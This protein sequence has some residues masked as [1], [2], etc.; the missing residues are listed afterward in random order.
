MKIHH[1]TAGESRT[2][3]PVPC[4][5]T[6]RARVF[7][8]LAA[9]LLAASSARAE[10]PSVPVEMEVFVR[11]GC[12]RCEEAKRF[13]T[14]LQA[15]RPA[16]QVYYRDVGR[17]PEALAR[18]QELAGRRTAGALGVPAFHVAGRLLVGFNGP[19]TTGRQLVA[20]L[21]GQA[22]GAPDA[23]VCPV[24]GESPECPPGAPLDSIEAP[25]VG[26]VS[27]RDWGLPAFTVVIGLLDGFNPC[28][29][30]VLLFLLSL[31][32]NL[33][34]R[35]KMLAVA[36]TFVLTSGLVYFA[37]MAAWLNVFLYLGLSRI[38]QVVLGGVALVIGAL[39]MKD[40]LAFK[41]GPS[42]SIP[43]SAKPGLY[44]R[45]RR[46]LQARSL[47]PA[48]GG[49]VALAFLVNLVEL[50]CTAGLPAIY[51]ELLV[52]QHLPGWRYY[53]YLALYNVAYILDDSV[54][55]LLAVVT[56]GH[57]KLQER[58]GRWLKLLSGSVMVLLGLLLLLR[59]QWLTF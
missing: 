54:M 18:L 27:L 20:L 22:P 28:A 2:A 49:V 31:L 48:M 30:W 10:A 38:T 36:G 9:G 55:V 7:G 24:G 59:P 51:T 3:R 41:H 35:R 52:L 12:P 14:Q 16:L 46:L 32:V 42:L 1:L 44:A 33:R 4:P 45:V 25:W 17:E 6:R 13:L 15:Q 57:H 43:E 26:R 37:F 34:S 50:A 58:A 39:N 23:A 19:E 56:L 29:M 21:E 11:E 53:A 40:F 5:P 47:L 8:L